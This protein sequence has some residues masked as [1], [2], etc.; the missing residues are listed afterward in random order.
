[1]N[2]IKILGVTFTSDC[3]FSAHIDLTVHKANA[4]LQTLTKMRRFGCDTE[5]LLYAYMCYVCLLLE[6]A[7]P[8]WGP[9]ATRTAYL[10]RDIECVQKRA[11]R[12]I[13]RNHDI[14]YDQALAKLNLSPL[15]VHLEH[16]IQQ[17]GNSVLSN[18]SHQ[19]ILPKPAPPNSQTRLKNKLVPPKVQTN[20]YANSFVPFFTSIFYAEL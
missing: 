6:H 8:V 10:L 20:H 18:K 15:K 9:S 14:P 4:R 17:F 19:S 16:L 5:S 1:M 12:I 2:K 13:L 7:C 3:S 11:T